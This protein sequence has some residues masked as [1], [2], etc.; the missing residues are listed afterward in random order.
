MLPGAFPERAFST[1]YA[2]KDISYA[3]R[4]AGAVGVCARGAELAKGWLEASRAGGNAE[5]YW[6]ILSRVI[7]REEA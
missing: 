2:L 5:A 1:D 7:D 4:L 3:L 6:P